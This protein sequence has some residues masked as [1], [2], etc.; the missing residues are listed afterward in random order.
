VKE[1]KRV[2]A[3]GDVFFMKVEDDALPKDAKPLP[4][5]SNYHI[6][7][8]SETGH[9]HAVR[10]D[11]TVF[12]EGPSDPFTCYLVVDSAYAD[13]VHQ[14]SFDTHETVR[15]EKGTWLV[16]RQREYTPEGFRRVED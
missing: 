10:A 16:R 11:G 9:H 3:Q 14:R 1:I 4:P 7:A 13:I 15:L 8:H 6:V 2:G 5:T 12:Y